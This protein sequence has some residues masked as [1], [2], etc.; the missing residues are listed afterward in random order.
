MAGSVVLSG[1]ICLVVT[2]V[3]CDH[4]QDGIEAVQIAWSI[5]AAVRAAGV[6]L[7]FAERVSVIVS[8]VLLDPSDDAVYTAVSVCVQADHPC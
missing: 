2:A 1:Y 5:A 3:G 7:P 4:V 8:G 6:D